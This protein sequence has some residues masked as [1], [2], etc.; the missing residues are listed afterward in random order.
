MEL[1]F[2]FSNVSH[3]ESHSG[4]ICFDKLE[5]ILNFFLSMASFY[6]HS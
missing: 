5:R 4:V 6:Q 1:L 3:I 2:V